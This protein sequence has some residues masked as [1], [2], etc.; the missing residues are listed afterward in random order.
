MSRKDSLKKISE[1]KR[2]LMEGEKNEKF[3]LQKLSSEFEPYFREFKKIKLRRVKDLIYNYNKNET[4]SQFNLPFKHYFKE[5]K[6]NKIFDLYNSK[7]EQI[8]EYKK[9]FYY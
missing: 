6:K 7:V 4:R 9:L 5:N 3:I 1:L 2:S 8:K